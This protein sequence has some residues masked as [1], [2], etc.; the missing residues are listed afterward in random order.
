[1]E[2]ADMVNIDASIQNNVVERHIYDCTFPYIE[3]MDLF[4][5]ILLFLESVTY[6]C[7]NDTTHLIWKLWHSNK[8]NMEKKMHSFIFFISSC[9]TK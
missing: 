6:R 4:S 2:N 5:N 1:M 7:G 3:N 8:L 9:T